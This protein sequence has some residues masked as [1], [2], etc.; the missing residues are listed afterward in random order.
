MTQACGGD[1]GSKHTSISCMFFRPWLFWWCEKMGG[2]L[3][4]YRAWYIISYTH[5]TG[6]TSYSIRRLGNIEKKLFLNNW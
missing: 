4:L 3:R 5:R 6:A 2:A 1:F